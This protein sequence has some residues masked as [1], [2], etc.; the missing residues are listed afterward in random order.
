MAYYII[1]HCTS[2]MWCNHHIHLTS[3]LSHVHLTSVTCAP[4]L[5]PHV[6]LTSVT[7]APHLC[8]MCTLPLSHVHLTSVTC[9]PHLCHM[10]TLPL[11]HVHL[12]SVT[13]TPHLTS[14]PLSCRV[15]VTRVSRSDL[16][17]AEGTVI[18]H[19]TF[20]LK[21]DQACS[22]THITKSV[23]YLTLLVQ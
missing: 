8:H 1:C 2:L 17:Q 22:C 11:S 21:Q 15:S 10:C 18:L 16:L 19:V 9:A 5:C 6:H 20:A 4:Y 23:L 3:L 13:C 7:C 14:S 12:T